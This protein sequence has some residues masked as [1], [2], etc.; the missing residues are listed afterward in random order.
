MIS[1]IRSISFLVL[2]LLGSYSAGY[3][4]VFNFNDSPKG[5]DIPIINV[6]QVD[7]DS[8]GRMWFS[9]INGVY[10]SDGIQTYTLPDS[11]I[12]DFDFRMSMHIDGDGIVWLYHQNGF[13]KLYKGG[14]GQWEEVV[15][16]IDFGNKQQERISFFSSGKGTEKQFYLNNEVVMLI[17][18]ADWEELKK[19]QSPKNEV[20]GR[21]NSVEKLAGDTYFFYEKQAL[22]LV[23][24][25]F[26]QVDFKGIELPSPP[27]MIKPSPFSGEFY[28]LGK[29]YLAKGL[30]LDTPTEILDSD[31][32]PTYFINSRYFGLFFSEG[33]VFYYYNSQL[34]KIADHNRSPLVLELYTLLNSYFIQDA[35]IDREGILWIVTPR[36]IVNLNNL[37]FRSFKKVK[38]EMMSPEVTAIFELGEN[39]LLFGFNNGI[40]RYENLMMKTVFRDSF[41]DGT[42]RERILNF[43][44]DEDSG[45]VWYSANFGGVGKYFP[46]TG[47]IVHYPSPLNHQITSVDVVGDSI[48]IAGTKAVY[49]APKSAKG[50]Q[51]YQQNLT[52][53]IQA[54]IQQPIYFFRKASKLKDGR[55]LVM[56]GKNDFIQSPL[57]ENERF[58]FVEGYD[59]LET[60]EGLLIGTDF[61]LKIYKDGKISAFQFMG[62]EISNPIYCILK[63]R[64]DAIWLGTDRG[65]IR[66]SKTDI[67]RFDEKNGLIGNEINRGALIETET[68]ELIIGTS[69]GFSIFDPEEKFQ[70][71]G[72][73]NIYLVSYQVG[74]IQNSD[75]VN[76]DVPYSENSFQAKFI[77]P[78]FD[79]S[80]DL[81]IHYRLLGLEDEEWIIIKDPKS[82]ELFF[83]NIPP[84][85]YQLELKASYDGEEFSDSVFSEPFKI[86]RLFYLQ[87]W[88]LFLSSIFLVSIGILIAVFYQQVE[89]L[90][91][92]KEAFDKTEEE[93]IAAEN[94]FKDVWN[95]SKDALILTLDMEEIVTVNPAFARLTG[96]REEAHTGKKIRDFFSN[97]DF[98]E[99]DLVMSNPKIIQQLI[100]GFSIETTFP[101]KTGP[102]EMELF[103][104]LIQTNFEHKNL[105][106]CVFRDISIEKAI[107]NELRNAKTRAEEANRYKSS[108]ISNISHEIRTPLNGILGGT[109]HIMMSRS[110]DKELLSQ[111]DIILQSGER[112]LGTINSIL[113]MAKIEANKMEVHYEELEVISYFRTILVPLKLQ[114][115]RKNIVIEEIYLPS[116]IQAKTDKRFLE[117]ILNNLLSNAI[118]YTDVG[119]VRFTVNAVDSNLILEISDTG[120]GMSLEYLNRIFQPFEQESDG[121]TRLYDGTGL[122]L[123]ITKNLVDMLGGTIVIQSEKNFGTVVKLQIPV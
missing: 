50:D 21:L 90:G 7:Q 32:S 107:E 5:V 88:F 122:G 121:H 87:F 100:K 45:E 22:K 86:N 9:T 41:S 102:L 113:D 118:K 116:A 64:A 82:N 89:K 81:W 93:K 120:I 111:L 60:E 6:R 105:I 1:Q 85:E 31:I 16:P 20:Y 23:N 70:A 48:L 15:L 26:E 63:D 44:K 37:K 104:K 12:S 99:T 29:N 108:L 14:Y 24:E 119:W 75:G 67:I 25:D 8:L 53:E 11:I 35:M 112:L 59:V 73:P 76:L 94:Q 2:I 69:R 115:S 103:S 55:I 34:K 91:T 62:E 43:S 80:K 110:H 92:L 77:A 68:G 40:Q 66:L 74:N 49:I 57:I 19:L 83:N 38:G 13:P 65:L 98:K 95:S 114:A 56:L 42:P 36:G 28:F 72:K 79:E 117:M 30:S 97:P 51:L 106:L 33:N 39:D 96:L 27:L 71:K 123:S 84:G 18:S 47:K 52:E 54:I 17:W 101:W 4:Q 10:Y 3:A 78:A 46:K 61:G 58:V 109:E